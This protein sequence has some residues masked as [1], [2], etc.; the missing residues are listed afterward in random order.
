MK[1]KVI[2]Y[3]QKVINNTTQNAGIFLRMLA[4]DVI[5]TST[6]NTPMKTGLLRRNTSKE[7]LGLKA[8]I[9]WLVHY[10]IYQEN[11]QFTN[12][13]TP[14]TGPHFAENA[15]NKVASEAESIMRKAK[16]I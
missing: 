12:Y 4:E 16:L 15:V 10:A 14:G 1:V 7:V 6:P 2:D 3:T 5:R 8:R 13:T 11:K 9:K